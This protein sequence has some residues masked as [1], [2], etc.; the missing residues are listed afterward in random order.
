MAKPE[1][2][3]AR[4]TILA[5]IQRGRRT[6]PAPAYALPP[7]NGDVVAAFIANARASGSEVREIGNPM[8]VP[9]AVWALL[10]AAQ[11]AP[12]LHIPQHSPL[13]ELSW[14]RA[15]GLS[16]SSESPSGSDS[17]LSRADY[18][19]AETGTLVFLSGAQSLSSWHFRPGREIALIERS[20]IFPRLEDVF[21][22]I[23]PRGIPATV[24]LVTGPSRTADIEQTIERGAHGPRAVDIFIVG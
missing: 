11:S 23:R 20:H 8:D 19:V 7:W 18:A 22:D 14:Q 13:A 5:A 24:N 2:S 15:P 9:E 21:A 12:R 4:E 3:S 17:A 10:A 16:I 1:M 6:V